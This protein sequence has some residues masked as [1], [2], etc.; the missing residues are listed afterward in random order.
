[1]SKDMKSL[2]RH[3]FKIH[4]TIFPCGRSNLFSESFTIE[5]EI[6]VFWFNTDDETTHVI[7]KKVGSREIIYKK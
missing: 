5:N 2:I 4:K 7:S 3:A 1:M 6:L